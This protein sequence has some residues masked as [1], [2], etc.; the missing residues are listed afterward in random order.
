MPGWLLRRLSSA[1]DPELSPVFLLS[2]I[3]P[4][5]SAR[6]YK[7][8]EGPADP[9]GQA[10]SSAATALFYVLIYPSCARDS[11]LVSLSP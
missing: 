3:K 1:N 7:D 2:G 9:E 11:L 5:W 6:G 10:S 8:K 4:T